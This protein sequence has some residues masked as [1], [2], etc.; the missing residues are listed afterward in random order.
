GASVLAV[1]RFLSPRLS[2]TSRFRSVI[3]ESVLEGILPAACGK[4]RSRSGIGA[5]ALLREGRGDDIMA[6]SGSRAYPLWDFWPVHGTRPWRQGL[7]A[8]GGYAR[9]SPVD[10]YAA[11]GAFVGRILASGPHAHS[12][13][14]SP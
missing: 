13:V 4:T 2:C 8:R 7:D 11:T 10:A 9:R 5:R 12:A 6:G 3:V 14:V 1:V